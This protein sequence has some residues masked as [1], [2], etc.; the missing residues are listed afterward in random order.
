MKRVRW[1]GLIVVCALSGCASE[2]WVGRYAPV[3]GAWT[4][5]P[6]AEPLLTIDRVTEDPPNSGTLVATG[7]ITDRA[8]RSLP[9]TLHGNEDGGAL[10]AES[11]DL[12]DGV[13]LPTQGIAAGGGALRIIGPT[14]TVKGAAR[15]TLDH[16]QHEESYVLQV[17]PLADSS[18]TADVHLAKAPPVEPR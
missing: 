3:D 12:G 11:V 13:V 9:V 10:F 1:A 8:K 15:I 14:V 18:K 4:V 7:T 16:G 2:T 5:A 6:D 17:A